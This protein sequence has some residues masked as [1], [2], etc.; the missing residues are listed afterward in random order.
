MV[1]VEGMVVVKLL[2]WRIEEKETSSGRNA[3]MA[4]RCGDLH[5]HMTYLDKPRDSLNRVTIHHSHI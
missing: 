3:F 4:G 5:L 2:V 1:V